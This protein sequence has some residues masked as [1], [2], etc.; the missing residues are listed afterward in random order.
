MISPLGSAKSPSLRS[1]TRQNHDTDIS[2]NEMLESGRPYRANGKRQ[3][4]PR[5]P[6]SPEGSDREARTAR[7]PWA[8]RLCALEPCLL[9]Y[10]WLTA[11]PVNT[12]GQQISSA[13]ATTV[14]PS[15]STQL[16]SAKERMEMMVLWR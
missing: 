6:F 15:S 9:G 16:G 8:L 14:S 7:D 11:F 10:R 13:N 12:N 4:V 3:P 5:R 2:V 1:H